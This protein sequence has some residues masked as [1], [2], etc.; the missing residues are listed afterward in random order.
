MKTQKI[1][2]QAL[3]AMLASDL[4]AH[5]IALALAG[6]CI[7]ETSTRPIADHFTDTIRLAICGELF[8]AGMTNAEAV[9]WYETLMSRIAPFVAEIEA[10]LLAA[11]SGAM[12]SE[13]VMQ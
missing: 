1:Q 11:P 10:S 7:A 3:E 5:T 2:R 9:F 12:I 6:V 4:Y 8:E 13:E